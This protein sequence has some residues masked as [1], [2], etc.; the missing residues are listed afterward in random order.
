MFSLSR[1]RDTSDARNFT[2]KSV[3]CG[4]KHLSHDRPSKGRIMCASK[5]TLP[6]NEG[7]SKTPTDLKTITRMLNQTKLVIKSYHKIQ[8]LSE[9]CNDFN[10]TKNKPNN[11]TNTK[12]QEIT[13]ENSNTPLEGSFSS[14]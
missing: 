13:L 4:D 11:K 1:F 14:L 2:P 5:H 9:I 8:L 3:K 10:Y 12:S 6:P 7:A